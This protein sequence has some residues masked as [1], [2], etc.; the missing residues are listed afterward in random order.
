MPRKYDRNDA[1]FQG[2]IDACYW[3]GFIAADG[4]LLCI[5]GESEPSTVRI[6]LAAR[7]AYHLEMFKAATEFAGPIAFYDGGA[8][9]SIA[10]SGARPWTADL[11]S[12]FSITPCKSKTLR[13]PNLT[14]NDEI[15]AFI[16]GL[17][18]GDGCISVSDRGSWIERKID[19]S[20]TEAL[21]VWVKVHLDRLVPARRIGNVRFYA[22]GL[23]RLCLGGLRALALVERLPVNLP[24]MSRKWSKL[25]VVTL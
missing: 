22:C 15:L 18:D 6:R 12:R 1:F 8:T 2:G 21:M 11:E 4:C 7:D 16:A 24:L 17:I 20:G 9:V 19:L 10:V 3:A 25:Q 13:P 23:A 14:D 5:P